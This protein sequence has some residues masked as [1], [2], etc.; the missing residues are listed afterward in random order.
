MQRTLTPQPV[1]VSPAP[2]K[3]SFFHIVG[4][5]TDWGVLAA[6][7]QIGKLTHINYA[8][9]LPKPDGT[10]YSIANGWKLAQYVEMAHA[11]GSQVLISVGG[12]GYD[13]QFEQLAASPATRATF[14]AEVMNLVDQYDLDG[15]D[16]DWEYPDPGESSRNFTAL[17]KEL[18]VE[19][20]KQGKLLTAAVVALGSNGEG[21]APEVF[22][23]VDY[24][25]I[26]VYDA[27]GAHH[28]TLQYAEEALRYWAGRG[29]PQA[30]RVLGVPFYAKPGDVPYRKL[31]NADASA[32][33]ADRLD[34]FHTPVTYNGIETIRSKTQLAL[35]SASGVMIWTVTD[36]TVD[37][38]SLL[39]AIY[40]VAHG[41]AP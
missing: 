11:Q 31:V 34:Y 26:M 13:K 28:S 5:V 32:A 22:E 10:L 37:E 25:N 40:A 36:D 3:T 4:Y 30:K 20:D 39:S 12:W 35:E 7:E 23:A 15:V 2:E 9:A 33:H 18:R 6:P 27:S 19:L 16:V 1:S 14:V 8:F 17:M 29:L 24:L 38:T 41:N 21:V